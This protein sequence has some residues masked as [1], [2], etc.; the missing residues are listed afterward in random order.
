MYIVNLFC[1]GG[2]AARPASKELT[3][4]LASIYTRNFW[5]LCFGLTNVYVATHEH[6]AREDT[7]AGCL[8]KEG[9]ALAAYNSASMLLP[10]AFRLAAADAKGV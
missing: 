9:D 6:Y 8:Y 4:S 7:Q 5:F 1:L 10:R 3:F 2:G